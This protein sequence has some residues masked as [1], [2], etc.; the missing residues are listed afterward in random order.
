MN[1][2]KLFL[3]LCASLIPITHAFNETVRDGITYNIVFS[4]HDDATNSNIYANFTNL[5]NAIIKLDYCRI[6]GQSLI[7]IEDV[8]KPFGGVQEFLF[9]PLI[10]RFDN[11]LVEATCYYMMQLTDTAF[12]N[13]ELIFF[14]KALWNWQYYG[15]T[16]SPFY[17][18]IIL[19]PESGH[20]KMFI[21]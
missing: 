15:I 12:V 1:I 8:I 17:N 2:T 21:K 7:P 19:L 9:K 11:M 20:V 16:S 14:H 18:T 10:S 3:L 4:R 13:V 5:S 6:N